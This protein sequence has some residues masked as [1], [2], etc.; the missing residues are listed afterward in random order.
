ME[1][2]LLQLLKVDFMNITTFQG[3]NYQKHIFK[4]EILNILKLIIKLK[5]EVYQVKKSMG[6]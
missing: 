5:L 4:V 1:I 2:R 3:K 6:I